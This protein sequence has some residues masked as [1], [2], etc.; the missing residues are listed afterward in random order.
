M[1]RIRK[2]FERIRIRLR[3]RGPDAA[4]DPDPY[5]ILSFSLLFKNF[6]F[7]FVVIKLVFSLIHNFP[8]H[9]QNLIVL[10]YVKKLKYLFNLLVFFYV[11]CLFSRVSD[12]YSLNPDPEFS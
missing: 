9:I 12:P 8:F 5:K 1:L 10:F 2:T 3:V 7:R 4:P 11:L 6:L